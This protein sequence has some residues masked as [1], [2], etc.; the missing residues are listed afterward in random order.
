M[1]KTSPI[2]IILFLA[3]I[4]ASCD[5]GFYQNDVDQKLLEIIDLIPDE[6]NS[7]YIIPSKQGYGI[8]FIVDD[9]TY[10][11][12]Y[13]FISPD[14][15]QDIEIEV[16][17]EKGFS[18]ASDKKTVKLLSLTLANYESFL[19]IEMDS[20]LN[21][22]NRDTYLPVT[23]SLISEI[24]GEQQFITN[25]TSAQI[26]GRGNSTWYSY[27]KKPYRLK[28]DES[29][30]LLGMPKSKDYVLLAEYADPSL[31]RNVVT[32]QLSKYFDLRHTLETRYVD[33]YIND[34]YLGVYVLTEQV[35]VTN[36]KLDLTIDADINDL[37]FFIELDMRYV[38]YYPN[39][40]TLA[41]IEMN[42]TYYEIKDLNPTDLTFT[43]DYRDA[44][45]NYLS[46][47]YQSFDLGTYQ[48]YV[49]IN[50]WIDY[51]IVQEITK[52][53]DN[54]YSSV[55]LFKDK[56]GK[57]TFGPLWDFD[58]AY[59]NA[60]YIDYGPVGFYGLRSDKNIWFNKMM[61]I[62][63]I[64]D[65]FKERF[66]SF[67]LNDKDTYINQI[68]E[69]YTSLELMLSKDEQV[70]HRLGLSIWPNPNEVIEANTAFKQYEY[71]SSYIEDR[72]NW[73]ADAVMTNEYQQGRFE[74]I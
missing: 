1:K 41:C 73:M 7:D 67:Y 63:E 13:E 21:D 32:H 27:P 57:L 50:Q 29:I 34:A 40:D 30:S 38:D 5:I 59:G 35:E 51:F 62:P 11:D 53:V 3:F 25:N 28:F 4:L 69:L 56:S 48:N 66:L 17:V 36:N 26:R 39:I 74:E 58:F 52:N 45:E 6:I 65:M 31:M 55:Y 24:N 37:S 43:K 44:I 68:H 14:T 23:T 12:V 10:V 49:D 20:D 72:V 47:A 15:D 61:Q 8:S 22:I 19:F 42:Q 46:E 71:L 33:L 54:W 70:W 9:I 60:D 2:L 18:K 16:V 64:R